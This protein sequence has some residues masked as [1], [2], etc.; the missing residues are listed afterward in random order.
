LIQLVQSVLGAKPATAANI[1]LAL[2]TVLASTDGSPALLSQSVP[3]WRAFINSTKASNPAALKVLP[4]LLT[5]TLNY[6]T[7]GVRERSAAT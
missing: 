1:G 3:W 2:A 6:L 5:D 7:A 4:K